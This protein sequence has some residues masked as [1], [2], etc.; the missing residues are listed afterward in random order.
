MEEGVFFTSFG[1][2]VT[3]EPFGNIKVSDEEQAAYAALTS[4]NGE[5]H[6]WFL[7][8]ETVLVEH[9]LSPISEKGKVLFSFLYFFCS[10]SS[11]IF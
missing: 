5:T 10:I 9:G 4:N 2:G 8:R 3:E 6:S 11:R 7:W 1:K